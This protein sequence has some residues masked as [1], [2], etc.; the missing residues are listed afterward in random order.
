MN[1][2]PDISVLMSVYNAEKYVAEAIESI[3]NQ[4][5]KNFE[6]II[7]ND[8]STDN[9]RNIIASYNDPRIRLF[10][11]EKNLHVA[12]TCNRSISLARSNLLVRMDADD[13]SVPDR[14][15]IQFDFMQKNPHIG[16][17]GGWFEQFGAVTGISKR[18]T[19][20]DM[21]RFS[22]LYVMPIHH[23]TA[24]MRKDVIVNNNIAYNPEYFAGEDHLFLIQIAEKTNVANIPKVLLKYRQHLNST[25]DKLHED[26]KYFLFRAT[27]YQLNNMGVDITRDEFILFLR[28]CYSDFNF[29]QAEFDCL[30]NMLLKMIIANSKSNYLNHAFFSGIIAQ[31]WFHLCYNLTSRM[32]KFIYSKYRQS[33]LSKLLYIGIFPNMKF[34]LKSRLIK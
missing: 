16:L 6:F 3:L 24:I 17:C 11:N 5:F 1:D 32:G 19:D 7:I 33:K 20:H 13:I 23:P 10:D 8:A 25:K 29:S 28:F 15:Q 18:V 4:T 14:L 31:K 30:E 22:M 27:Q 26:L 12:R 34:Y 2:K 9:S 21:I